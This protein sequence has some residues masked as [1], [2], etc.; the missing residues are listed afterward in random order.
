M[1]KV[2]VFFD[3]NFAVGNHRGMGKY[4]NTFIDVL[5]TEF[6]FECTGLLKSNIRKDGYTTFGF[7]NYIMWEQ[8]S[9][10]LNV[11]KY[12]PDW[13]VYPYNTAPFFMPKRPKN[14][15]MV[16]DLIFLVPYKEIGFSS[17]LVQNIGKLYRR[18]VVPRAI[19]NCDLIITVSQHT[20]N[21]IQRVFNPKQ[22]IIV[23]P[24]SFEK[25]LITEA[26]KTESPKVILHVGGEAPHK[27][28]MSVISAY[29]RLPLDIQLKY[30]L[31]ILG[32]HS[33]KSRSYFSKQI[34]KS[35]A[36]G[37]I[38]LVDFITNDAL[39]QIYESAVVFVFPSFYEGFGIP[40]IE[41]MSRS[42]PIVCSNQSVMPEIVGSGG[43]YFDPNDIDDQADKIVTMLTD[44]TIRDQVVY[45]QKAKIIEYEISSVRDLIK[46]F[47]E[48]EIKS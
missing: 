10:G 1:N 15:L 44:K 33:P 14:I 9:I 36:K 12:R 35:G 29:A 2:K 28:T 7:S 22:E 30:Q 3:A 32:I 23:I 17:S 31:K 41:A 6:N 45:N 24:N 43:L 13:V 25:G 18:L 11:R 26:K 21:E 47:I 27:N 16:H 42:I 4:V 19:K 40:L 38:E 48:R 5:S 34:D 39:N 8:V 20:K 37:D 46:Q